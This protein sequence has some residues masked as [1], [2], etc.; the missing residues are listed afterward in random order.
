MNIDPA[1]IRR[2]A[3]ALIPEW[4]AKNPTVTDQK[5]REQVGEAADAFLT[6][7]QHKGLNVP[8]VELGNRLA[9]AKRAERSLEAVVARDLAARQKTSEPT[10]SASP[11]RPTANYATEFAA[12]KGINLEAKR[13]TFA[14]MAT[15]L[16][17]ATFRA[18]QNGSR[19]VAKLARQAHHAALMAGRTPHED[20]V[21]L[22]RGEV[23]SDSDFS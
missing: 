16:E 8:I 21:T 2:E 13:P 6:G 12:R 19:D 9:A 5:I 23:A 10:H 7:K 3:Q 15:D 1:L 20:V 22:A 17:S 4:R 18:L 14:A 11:T